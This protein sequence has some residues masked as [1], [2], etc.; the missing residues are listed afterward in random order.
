MTICCDMTCSVRMECR[1]FL[2]ALDVNS[3][4][5]KDYQIVECN[6]ADQYER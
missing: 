3:G 5:A 4:K 2:N 1:K 6:H